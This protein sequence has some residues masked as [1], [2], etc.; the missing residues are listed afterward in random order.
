MTLK[1]V[2]TKSER[3]VSCLMCTGLLLFLSIKQKQISFEV[4]KYPGHS[5][6]ICDTV[7]RKKD[8]KEMKANFKLSMA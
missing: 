1:Y 2:L 6:Y 3:K 4:Y 8:L 5:S 7:S